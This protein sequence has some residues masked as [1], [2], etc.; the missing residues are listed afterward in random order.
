MKRVQD[1]VN[2]LEKRREGMVIKAPEDGILTYNKTFDGGVIQKISLGTNVKSKMVIIKLPD[3][4]DMAVT[5]TL[6]ERY[7][8]SIKKGIKVEI[9]IPSAGDKSFKGTVREIGYIFQSLTI[10][11]T[12]LGIYSSQEPLGQNVFSVTVGLDGNDSD[13][14]PGTVAEV[15][16]P[17]KR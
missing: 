1:W 17:F 11:S 12:Q 6:D 15:Y 10:K 14:K 2:K 16:F 13:I 9:K 5:V 4:S 3:V 7:F 8:S